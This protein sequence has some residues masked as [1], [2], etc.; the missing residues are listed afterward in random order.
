MLELLSNVDLKYLYNKFN[1]PINDILNKDLFDNITTPLIGNYI[2]NLQDSDAGNGTHWVGLILNTK[3]AIY[4]DSF[5]FS[6]PNDII[7]FIYKYNKNSKIIYSTDHIQHKNS[8]LCGWY[9]MYFHY[10]FN[11]KKQYNYK[12]LINLHNSLFNLNNRLINDKILQKL[13]TNI[14]K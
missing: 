6:I 4:Y 3:N 10:L 13:I 14:N 5:G 1:I 8:I 12:K 11:N 7:H 2:I 9:T